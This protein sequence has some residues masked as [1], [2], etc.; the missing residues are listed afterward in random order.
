MYCV[1]YRKRNNA[2]GLNLLE[3]DLQ[4]AIFLQKEVEDLRN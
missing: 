1:Y 4:E 3:C 2:S